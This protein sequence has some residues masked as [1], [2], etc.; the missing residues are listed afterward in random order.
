MSCL[1]MFLGSAR[2]QLDREPNGVGGRWWQ[3]Q[4]DRVVKLG[5]VTYDMTEVELGDIVGGGMA[6]RSSP[7]M[8]VDGGMAEG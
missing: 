2:E 8:V 5:D 7:G 1:A 4:H 3:W 6:E